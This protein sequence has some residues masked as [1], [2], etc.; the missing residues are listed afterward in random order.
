MLQ[1]QLPSIASTT[2]VRS[3]SSNSA[4]AG[5]GSGIWKLNYRWSARAESVKT[6]PG[7]V[8]VLLLLQRDFAGLAVIAADWGEFCPFG[9]QLEDRVV[10]DCLITVFVQVC[11]ESRTDVMV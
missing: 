9:V 4:G 7:A 6:G 10:G 2:T 11:L 1:V 3:Y 8:C 5:T